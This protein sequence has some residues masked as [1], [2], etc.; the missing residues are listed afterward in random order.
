MID[1]FDGDKL[2]VPEN[3][4]NDGVGKAGFANPEAQLEEEGHEGHDR[5]EQTFNLLISNLT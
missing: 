5:F 4:R 1:F 3:S 2:V